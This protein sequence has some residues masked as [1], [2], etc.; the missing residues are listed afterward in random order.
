[1]NVKLKHLRQE[2]DGRVYV[3]R[4]GKSLRLQAPPGSPK[5]LAEYADALASIGEPRK[6]QNSGKGTLGWLCREYFTSRDFKAL[7]PSSQ[8][9]RRGILEA[10]CGRHGDKPF[11]LME[12]RHIKMLRDEKEGP[13]ASNNLLK[14]LKRMFRWAHEKELLSHNPATAVAQIKHKTD[15]HHTWTV[16]E[17]R[18][19]EA[20][21][22]TGTTPRLALALLLYTGA[23]RGDVIR[24]GPSMVK[25]GWLFFK[26][27]K[28]GALVSV[29]VSP[30]L[31]REIDQ[32]P[33]RP[34]FLV[35]GYGKPYS[36]AGFG[37]RF[38]EW[39]DKAALHHCSAHG[40]RKAGATLAAERGA[41]ES[42]LNAIFGW[43]EGSNE[44]RRYTR[45]A[46]RK[47]LSG[48]ATQLISLD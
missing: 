45:A 23:R 20:A 6:P 7:A 19:F 35:G 25:D 4:N 40:L 17:V 42:E 24:F 14:A 30:E 16:E 39:C 28:T 13:E 44:A 32:T 27:E 8:R 1:M 31:Q 26:A 10:V 38:R 21:H 43:G 46:R 3:R 36:A 29:P 2:K 33:P 22:A 47:V 11:A 15:G 12:P 18:Q 48:R 34:T 37:I 41:T 5:F 9:V